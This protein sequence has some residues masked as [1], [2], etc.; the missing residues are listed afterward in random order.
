MT[1]RLYRPLG[2]ARRPEVV[3][4]CA[5]T[6]ANTLRP[7]H[8]IGLKSRS[9]SPISNGCH[10]F[11]GWHAAPNTFTNACH[12]DWSDMWLI[13][14]G[15]GAHPQG[16]GDGVRGGQHL[17]AAH[18]AAGLH[19]QLRRRPPCTVNT[20]PYP[21][22]DH[23]MQK[24]PARSPQLQ[25]TATMSFHYVQLISR[26]THGRTDVHLINRRTHGLP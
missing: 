20:R 17:H 3:D 19:P 12:S 25:L 15:V 10:L 23:Q 21:A 26:K 4:R 9:P 8:H 22:P 11:Q 1:R 6:R 18:T 5:S 7:D 16:T 14:A 24:S 13:H 2:R